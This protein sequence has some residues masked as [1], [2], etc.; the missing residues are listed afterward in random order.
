MGS[1]SYR[2]KNL[3][4]D[5]RLAYDDVRQTFNENFLA[6]TELA[7]VP[8]GRFRNGIAIVTPNEVNDRHGTGVI[9]RRSFDGIPN[10]LSIRSHDLHGEHQFGEYAFRFG[11]ESLSRWERFERL[12][13]A[14]HGNTFR[15]AICVPYVPND[16]LT[17]IVLK[18]LFDLKL[19][20]Y[21]MDDN[22][23]VS[24]QIPE[25]L[26]REALEK[27]D[28]RLAI[29]P[30]MRDAY[31]SKF[32]LK[33]WLR[34]PPVTAAAV[35]SEA[36]L[37]ADR[38]LASRRGV[39][40]GSLWSRQALERLAETVSDA[41]IKVDWFGNS[42]ASWLNADVNWLAGKGITVRG[43]LSEDH[44]LK[45]LPE[46]GYSLVP[47][48]TLDPDDAR[49]DIA[50]YSL[51]TRMPFLMAAGNIPIIVLGS[52]ETAAAAFVEGFQ[53]GMVVNYRGAELHSAVDRLANPLLQ[54][55][56][57]KRAAAAAVHFSARGVGQW[58]L[59]SM[60]L[61]RPVSDNMEELMPRKLGN[62]A[63]YVEEP[64]P[65]EVIGDFAQLYVALRRIR[66]IG[67][68][69]DFVC[70]VG[71][72]TGIWSTTVRKI[73]PDARFLLFEPLYS[74]YAKKHS[75]LQRTAA[76]GELL[77]VALGADVGEIELQVSSD[78]Y[79]SSILTPFDGRHYDAL[80][81]PMTTLDRVRA[82]R[83]IEGRGVLK[84]DVQGAEHLVLEGARNLLD[85]IDLLIAELSL[86]PLAKG[87]KG[88]EEMYR[89]LCEIGFEYY[90]DVGEW[91]CPVS[92][93]LLQK[94]VIFI[95][96]GLLP[97]DVA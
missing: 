89:M 18:E 23:L 27:A 30:E 54:M 38:V 78:L 64:A 37:P 44:L 21:V 46:Y 7:K 95:R 66:R 34:P 57:R 12:A 43:F 59:D 76:Q 19:C 85:Q 73:F 81:V 41:G 9:M 69:P 74:V 70:D 72:S 51:P 80:R 68:Q 92:G 86:F 36:Q 25:P 84:L 35:K 71:A 91:R 10:I 88:F 13:Q 61:G 97:Y 24:G 96:R 79:G 56:I 28:L 11:D 42:D 63:N 94:D 83:K 1:I 58:I 48:G 93:R 39:V 29:S 31:E 40:I 82:E 17:A 65:G 26:M 8:A 20:V 52:P 22:H 53:V 6:S 33:F 62:L 2:I 45:R 32:R 5:A 90:D 55:D 60:D 15:Y 49:P 14:L 77:Q 87:A 16:L 4:K 47:T 67:F 50:R 75:Y 3:I